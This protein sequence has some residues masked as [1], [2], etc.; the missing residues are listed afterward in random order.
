MSPKSSSFVDAFMYESKILVI[1]RLMIDP[2][3]FGELIKI[4]FTC[5]RSVMMSLGSSDISA[6]LNMILII[7]ICCTQMLIGS[8]GSKTGRNICQNRSNLSKRSSEMYFCGNL[9]VRNK[10][11]I[12]S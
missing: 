5:G 9:N 6:F 7:N 4:D 8:L 12:S 2:S 3:M 1:D 11:T 10:F